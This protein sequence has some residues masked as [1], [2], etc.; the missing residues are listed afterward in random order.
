MFN[1]IKEDLDLYSY[2]RGWSKWTIA[3]IPFIFPTTWPVLCYRYQR[4]VLTKFSTPIIKQVLTIFGYLWK[5]TVVLLTGV[6]ISDRAKIGEGLFIAHLGNIVVGHSTVIGNYCSLHQGVTFGGSW[7]DGEWGNPK[8]GNNL[9]ISAGAVVAGKILVGDNVAIGANAVVI[10]D[11]SSNV[12]VGGVPA[13]VI[14]E[15]GSHGMIHFR[16]K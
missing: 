3:I 16:K 8:V 5:M 9:Y 1:N 12:S 11:V 4:W 14:S 6:T 13:K 7:T 15:K 10:K 2:R